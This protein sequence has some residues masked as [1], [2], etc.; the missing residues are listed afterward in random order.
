MRTLHDKRFS[1]MSER[2]QCDSRG[3]VSAFP[4]RDGDGA[5]VQVLNVTIA[6]QFPRFRT[7]TVMERMR[8]E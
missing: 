4:G 6:V 8:N 7:A 5:D 1:R 3:S 2:F